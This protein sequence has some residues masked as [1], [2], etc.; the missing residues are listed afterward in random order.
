MHD[1]G[2]KSMDL[3]FQVCSLSLLLYT[4]IWYYYDGHGMLY[5]DSL[6]IESSSV[7]DVALLS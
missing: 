4:P 3:L 2:F 5:G 7:C 1:S 6:D